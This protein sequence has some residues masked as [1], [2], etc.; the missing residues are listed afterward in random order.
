MNKILKVVA[1]CV[2]LLCAWGVSGVF[3]QSG[4]ERPFITKWEGTKGEEL[5]IPI[6]GKEYQLVIKDE[7]N[8]P[9]KDQKVTVTEGD[10]PYY[11]FTPDADGIYTV[12]AGPEGVEYMQMRGQDYGEF[13]TPFTSNNKLQQVVQFGTVAW[14]SAYRMFYG[15]AGMTFDAGIDTPDLS[16][17]TNMGSMFYGCSPFNQSLNDWKVDNVTNMSYM[18]YNCATFNQ[19][20]DKWN[21]SNVTNMSYMFCNCFRFNKSLNDWKVD[22]VTNM[23]YMFSNCYGF[24]QPL[25]NWNVSNVT[26]MQRMF[27]SNAF[28][29]QP[30][31][32]W[33]VSNVTSMRK[34]FSECAAFNQSLNNWNVSNVT[35]MSEMFMH[36]TAFNKPL[37]NWNVSNVTDMSYM[38]FACEAFNQPPENWEVSKVTNMSGMFSGCKLF[39]QSL[40]KWNVANVTDMN[41]MFN[42]CK[43][44]KQSLENWNVSNV[45]NTSYMFYGCISFNSPLNWDVSNVESMVYMFSGCELFNQPLNWNVSNVTNMNSMFHGCTSFN[46]P[47]NWNVSNVTNMNSMF[48]GCTSFNQPL[49]WDVSNVNNMNSMFHGCSSFNQPLNWDVSNV[50]NME[51]MFERCSAFDQSLGT[52]K[53]Q[54]AVG[55]LSFTA[56]SL[57]NYSKTLVGWANG[58]DVR[59]LAFNVNGRVYNS[60]AKAARQKLIERGWNFIGDRALP[61]FKVTIAPVEHGIIAIEGKDTE[62]LT[63]IDEGTELTVLDTPDEGYELKELTANDVDIFSTRKFRVMAETT[64]KAKFEKKTFK[65]HENIVGTGSL[66]FT[67]DADQPLDPTAVPYETTV[68]VVP[69]EN[70]PWELVSLMVGTEDITTPQSFVLKS[71]VT[72][73]AVF[74]DKNVPT[75]KV[76]VTQTE[77]GTIAIPGYTTGALEKVS[78]DTDLTVA[79]TPDAEHGYKLKSLKAGDAD[80]TETKKFTVTADTEV[81]AVFELLTFQITPDVTGEGC[82]L[83]FKNAATDAAITDLNAVPY[84]TKVKVVPVKKDPWELK[85][86]S[87]NGKDIF[88]AKEFTIKEATTVTAVFKK[89]LPKF[90]VTLTQPTNGKI[91]IDG[92]ATETSITVEQG[93][94]LTVAVTPDKGYK[95]KELKAGD[96]DIT[97][98]KQFTV[99]AATEVKALFEKQTFTVKTSV[100]NKAWGSIELTGA[101]DLKVVEY[102]TELTVKATPD[103][104]YKLKTLKANNK[105]ITTILKFTVTAATTVTAVFEK[106]TFAVTTSVNNEAWGAIELTGASDLS[107][108]AYGTE[109][110]VKVTEKEGYKLKTLTAGDKDITETKKFTVKAA[111]EVKAVFESKQGGAVE[112]ALLAGIVVAPNPF[113]SQLRILNPEGVVARYELVNAAGMV[114]RSGALSEK[115]LVVDTETLSSGIYFVR[116]EAQNGAQKSVMVS[117]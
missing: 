71:E 88:A 67:D 105:D 11:T 72:V 92:H 59:D 19:P 83:T 37:N 115:E 40:E 58:T 65:L 60:E 25:E 110:T 112:D 63:E 15:C 2:V 75:F 30:L 47:L 100:N 76:T 62:A 104:G 38:F 99:T 69:V 6:V 55:G 114:V 79:V 57:E 49:N 23:S 97:N 93:T 66:N 96:E 103:E 111:T 42:D 113:T 101:P 45:T 117:K 22:N 13:V 87:A 39:N 21:V 91:A 34:M 81:K 32:N 51:G 68:K 33:N 5:K 20:L 44:F 24:N 70:D 95:L 41:Y 86:L 54:T 7:S 50:N 108:V 36:C 106:E 31:D 85:E 64:V 16:N 74:Q 8:N 84:G 98:S 26:D 52:W 48:H 61:T 29:N 43:A 27:F 18:F 53:I 90:I 77:G 14:T 80:I 1:A 102:G 82:S 4:T 12:E 56:M 116:I 17:V 89:S 3:A 46:Q 35:G 10:A 9:V 109:L 107:S 94:T 78:K 73:Y 28:F